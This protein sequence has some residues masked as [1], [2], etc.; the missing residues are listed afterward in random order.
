MVTSILYFK[1]LYRNS[2]FVRKCNPSYVTKVIESLYDV[3][4]EMVPRIVFVIFLI[5]LK[6]IKNVN[7]SISN[8]PVF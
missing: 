2:S 3:V 6:L 1:K 8:Y 7:I 4:T 5:T